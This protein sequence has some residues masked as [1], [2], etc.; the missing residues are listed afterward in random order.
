MCSLDQEPCFEGLRKEKN[1][2]HPR[3]NLELTRNNTEKHCWKGTL[4]LERTLLSDQHLHLGSSKYEAFKGLSSWEWTK[5]RISTDIIHV[6]TQA[7]NQP[8]SCSMGDP[9]TKT[10]GVITRYHT[11]TSHIHSSLPRQVNKNEPSGRNQKDK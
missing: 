1:E 5:G 11:A 9:E 8:P 6:P 4:G 2:T 10:M 3:M 7:R